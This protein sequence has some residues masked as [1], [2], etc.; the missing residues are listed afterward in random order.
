[1]KHYYQ[2]DGI[3]LFNADCRELLAEMEP[4]SVDA[5]VTDPP[6]GIGEAR[7]KNK[8][9][10]NAAVARD[11]GVSDWDDKPCPPETIDAMRAVSRWQVIF[12]GNYF[13]L[14]PSSCW[15]VWDKLITGD[16]ADCELAWTNLKKAVRR[17]VHRWNGMIREGNEQRFHPTQKPLG[18][19]EWCISQ[20][21]Q[22]TE[23]ILDPFCGVATT[24]VAAWNLGRKAILCEISEEYCELGAK[25]LDRLI[26][27]GRLFKPAE[28]VTTQKELFG[29]SDSLLHV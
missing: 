15:L 12:G 18:V 10:T 28:L 22:D 20:L 29:D 9:R 11:Y 27:Q 16:F 14:P 26:D 4:G 17:I 8:S 1:M 13:H 3:T 25:R 2:R 19:M 5:V 21:P 24:G 23:L 6:Y 7:G